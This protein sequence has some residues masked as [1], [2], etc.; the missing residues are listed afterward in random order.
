MPDY[1]VTVTRRVTVTYTLKDCPD[2]TE[3]LRN[4]SEYIVDEDVGDDES[5]DFPHY[6]REIKL[7]AP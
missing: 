5:D 7:V 4:Y 1:E 6:V 2:A 3:A